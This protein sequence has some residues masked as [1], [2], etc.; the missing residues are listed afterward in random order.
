[1]SDV[2]DDIGAMVVSTATGVFQPLSPIT[3]AALRESA[4]HGEFDAAGW[5]ALQEA[6]FPQ[7][8]LPEERGGIGTDHAFAIARLAGAMAIPLPIVETM[9][10]NWLLAH[11]GLEPTDQPLGF[12]DAAVTVRRTDGGWRVSGQAT[13]VPWARSCGI[14]LAGSDGDDSYIVRLEPGSFDSEPGRN[15]AGEPRDSCTID[16]IVAANRVGRPDNGTAPDMIRAI[17]ALL[18][19]AQIAGA[20]SAAVTMTVDY[21]RDRRQFGKP[22]AAFQAVQQ[23][24]AVIATQAAAAGVAVDL[25]VLGLDTAPDMRKVAIAKSRTSEAAGLVAA[26]AHQLH[27][28]MGFTREYPLHLL[29]R[30]L[31]SWRDEFSSESEWAIA[32]G[33]D[34]APSGRAL[35]SE[36]TRI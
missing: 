30:R 28:A 21:V 33:R 2:A 6:G 24:L 22:L 16:L 5:K 11:A 35:W 20:I 25:G 3:N 4:E 34:L 1:M 12:S 29:S 23:L 8:L 17:G 31:W 32:L 19:S 18:R 13:A 9:G 27:G 36:I 26:T 7:A 14:L 10:A 15:K